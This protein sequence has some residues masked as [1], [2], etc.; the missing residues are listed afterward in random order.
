MAEPEKITCP[1]K[2]PEIDVSNKNIV[3][4]NTTDNFEAGKT[5]LYFD[6]LGRIDYRQ[7]WLVV[8]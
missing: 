7:K 4:K 2:L 3:L 5:Q 1:T 6:I 8:D